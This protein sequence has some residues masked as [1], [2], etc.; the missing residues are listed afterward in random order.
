MTV[1]FDTNVLVAALV[2]DHPKHG[3]SSPWVRRCTE[4]KDQGVFSTHGLAELYATLTGM[5]HRPPIRPYE[6]KEGL[7]NLRAYFTLIALTKKNYQMALNRMVSLSIPG[8]GIY[9][10]LHARAALKA[11][12]DVLLTLNGKHF[13]RL[14]TDVARLV[15]EPL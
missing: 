3:A 11:Q 15:Q 8:G 12:V 10:A 14:G 7:D 6:V 13:T 1:Y 4:G 5:P 2:V 9:D